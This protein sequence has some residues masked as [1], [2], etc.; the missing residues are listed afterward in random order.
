MSP[1]RVTKLKKLLFL[2]NLLSHSTEDAAK[3]QT[4]V[5]ASKEIFDK[6]VHGEFWAP[7]I[8]WKPLPGVWMRYK[9]CGKEKLK[10]HGANKDEWNRF[11]I[12]CE[13]IMKKADSESFT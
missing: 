2:G 3:T 11:W 4:F 12:Y 1:Q 8:S 5:S 10:P 7:Y 6:H 13:D 9:G